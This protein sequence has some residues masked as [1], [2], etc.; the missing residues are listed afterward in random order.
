MS[1]MLQCYSVIFDRGISAPGHGK[2]VSNGLNVIYKSYIYQLISNVQLP[3]SKLFDS[4]IIMH[5]C[6]TALLVTQ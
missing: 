1:G 6:T 3:G 2:D 4:Q 5:Y